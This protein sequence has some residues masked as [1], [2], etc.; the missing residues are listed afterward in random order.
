MTLQQEIIAL[1]LNRLYSKRER[2]YGRGLYDV[3]TRYIQ[4]LERS[5]A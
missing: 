1:R 5:A 4:K 3:I 2:Y